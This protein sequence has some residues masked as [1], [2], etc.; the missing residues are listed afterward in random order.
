MRFASKMGVVIAV[1]ILITGGTAYQLIS[2]SKYK[3]VSPAAPFV[4]RADDTGYSQEGMENVSQAIDS[5]TFELFS[6][7][8]DNDSNL[9]FSPYSIETAFAMAY[10]GARGQTADE[11][12]SVFHFVQDEQVRRSS[13][14]ALYNKLN[15]DAHGFALHTANAVWAQK[16]YPILQQYIDILTRY[17]I[18]TAANVDF[19]GATEQA[20]QTIN[21]WVANQTAG[22][23]TDLFP[24]W[25]LTSDTVLALTN[26]VYFKASWLHKF[27]PSN[28][29]QAD[30]HVNPNLTVQVPMMRIPS[31]DEVHFNYSGT[32]D[33]QILELPYEGNRLSMLILLPRAPDTV[34]LERSLTPD[35]ITQWR[36]GLRPEGLEVR[37]PRFTFKCRYDLKPTLIQMGMPS[38]FDGSADF[39]G[40]DGTHNLYIDTAV[41]QAYI[42]VNEQ[43]TEAGAATGVGVTFAGIPQMFVADHPFIFL[44]QDQETGAILFMG[45]VVDPTK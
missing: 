27:N 9:F 22:K 20:R 44:I 3:P 21:D 5:F 8:S 18:A 32:N 11:M 30:F 7:L 45:M 16:D 28:T 17:Y 6:N 38:A 24:E 1:S 36:A 39:S 42:T 37:L 33:L 40:M 31:K 23:I 12:R 29:R 2:P 25:S 15:I 43:G 13:Y 41:H 34:E 26:A 35:N 14:A 4:A 10:E 19:A